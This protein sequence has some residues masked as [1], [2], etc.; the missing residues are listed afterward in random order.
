MARASAAKATTRAEAIWSADRQGADAGRSD[1]REEQWL[2]RLALLAGV[3]CILALFEM[4]GA[5]SSDAHDRLLLDAAADLDLFSKAVWRDLSEIIAQNH[6][7]A[8]L[9]EPLSAIAPLHASRGRSIVV[10]DEQD[11]VAATW[12]Q[13]QRASATLFEMLGEQSQ[14]IVERSGPVRIVLSDGTPALAIIRKLPAPF[15]RI[16]AIQPQSSVLMDWRA[17]SGRHKLLLAATVAVLLV[18]V[19]CGV[20]S[21]AT[22]P[23]RRGSQPPNQEPAGDGALAR[24]LR[25][26]GLGHRG[27]TPLLVR[28]D[29]EMLG[30][31]VEGGFLTVAELAELIH[32]DDSDLLKV[33]TIVASGRATAADRE[34]RIRHASG[35]WIWM[36]ARSQAILDPE[37]KRTHLV[38]IA[39][40]VSEQKA[41]AEAKE[42]ADRRLRDA[43]DAA[44]KPSFSGIRTIGSSPATPIFSSFTASRARTRPRARLRGGHEPRPPVGAASR[45]GPA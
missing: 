3:I 38:G 44:S 12:P 20:P 9:D 36:R 43:I 5:L 15:G 4:L 32:P 25:P 45:A 8:A 1:P 39:F 14:A 16:A 19:A 28:L 37:T 6:D 27:G 7:K 29:A 34:F 40:D 2:R 11:R 35:A 21:G 33:A 41:L 30:R 10:T 42:A 26:M 23:G 31:E 22:P 17:A 24:A 18:I 13:L